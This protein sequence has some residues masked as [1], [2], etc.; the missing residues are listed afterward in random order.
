M[1]KYP[2]ARVV[3]LKLFVPEAAPAGVMLTSPNMIGAAFAASSSRPY[4]FVVFLSLTNLVS[5]TVIRVV[6]PALT[7]TEMRFSRKALGT[8]ASWNPKK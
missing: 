3:V 7:E 8:E 2:F 6:E 1:K 5:L 4:K